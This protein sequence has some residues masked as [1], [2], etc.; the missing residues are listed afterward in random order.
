MLGQRIHSISEYQSSLIDPAPRRLLAQIADRCRV[1]FRKPQHTAFG[2][3]QYS[4]PAIE[5]VRRE[6]EA[7]VEAAKHERR[8]RQAEFL[9]REGS[10]GDSVARIE[11]HEA[12]G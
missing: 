3:S 2:S 5:D 6:L 8:G 7:V 1:G 12:P 10:C 11:R 4:H 9:A